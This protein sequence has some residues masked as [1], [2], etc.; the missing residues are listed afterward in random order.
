[1]NALTSPLLE[2]RELTTAFAGEHGTLPVVDGVNLRL[3]PGECVG[4]VG[5]SGCGKSAVAMSAVRLLPRPSG[6]IL[7]GQ[8]LFRGQDL[9]ALPS[10]Q[11][12]S[13]RGA[14]IGVIFQEALQALN[15]VQRIGQQIAEPLM[16]HLG[17]SEEEALQRAR[18]LLYEYPPRRCAR[19]STRTRSPAA[20]ASGS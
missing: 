7:A 6:R 1:M 13:I 2:I 19:G 15:P 16:L 11:L 17:M 20:C 9:L 14:H 3:A 12:N 8:A 10:R 18:E 5:E 4:I